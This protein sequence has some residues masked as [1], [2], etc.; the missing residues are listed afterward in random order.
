MIFS[1]YAEGPG[2][3]IGA[4]GRYDDLLERFGA[5]MPAVGF[6]IDIDALASALRAA[7]KRVVESTGIVIIGATDSLLASLRAKNIGC[8]A[9][10]DRAAAEAYARSWGF[11]KVVDVSEATR[12]LSASPKE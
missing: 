1:I 5:P 2:E 7:G 9:A 10:S 4:G 8:V 11:A 6:G 3:R 12:M